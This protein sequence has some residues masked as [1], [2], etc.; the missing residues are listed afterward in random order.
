MELLSSNSKNS[1]NPTP[2]LK[3]SPV[4]ILFIPFNN[5]ENKCNYCENEY[6]QTLS[7]QKFC[8]N[9]LFDYVNKLTDNNIYLD[10]IYAKEVQ[11]IEHEDSGT[12]NIQEWCNSCSTISH[13]NQEVCPNC[14]F[15]SSEWIESTLIK[16]LIPIVYLPW[17][18]NSSNCLACERNLIYKSDCQKWCSHSDID[19]TAIKY[20]L[21]AFTRICISTDFVNDMNIIK[22]D[23]NLMDSVYNRKNRR[24][25]SDS[26]YKCGYCGIRYSS[27]LLFEQLYCK[28]CLYLYLYDLD[29]NNICLDVQISNI[30]NIHC[31]KHESKN[32]ES[33]RYTQNIREW[34]MNCSEILY[35]KQVV[36]KYSFDVKYY[37]EKRNEIIKC[38]KDRK[39]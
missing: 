2:R 10:V 36:T 35:F 15:I 17:W 28:Y 38:E 23:S 31:T 7:E 16:K 33:Y 32:I 34:C 6:S 37:Y 11:C 20:D 26:I 1:F 39:V 12:Q 3:S 5:S 29:D 27:T 13:F 14:Y 19:I 24:I 4:P 8:K 30:S 21:V 22:Q 9:C 18:D 25:R